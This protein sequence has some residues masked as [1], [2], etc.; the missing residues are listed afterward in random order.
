MDDYNGEHEINARI[1]WELETAMRR[2]NI[3]R[4]PGR[5]KL[6]WRFTA[7]HRAMTRT[8]KSGG[9]DAIRYRREV[10]LPKLIPFAKKCGLDFIVQ[11][12]KAP[13]HASHFQQTLVY[14]IHHVTRLLWPGNSPD[15]NIIKPC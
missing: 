6:T 14:D 7:A 3:R 11:E 12:D 8:G 13:A 15:L 4:N 10:L 1:K 9:I 2:L 5:R